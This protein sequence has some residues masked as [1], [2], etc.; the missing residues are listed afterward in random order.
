VIAPVGRLS[1]ANATGRRT[2]A[3]PEP[4]NRR[5]SSSGATAVNPTF[6]NQQVMPFGGGCDDVALRFCVPGALVTI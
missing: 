4:T 6:N 5:G 3:I 2:P 1:L